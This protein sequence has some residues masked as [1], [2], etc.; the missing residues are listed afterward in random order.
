MTK[1]IATG[2]TIEAAVKAGLSQLQ[3]TEDR[4]KIEVLEQPSKGLF[5]FIG[6]KEAKVE[7]ELLPDAI[8]QAALFLKDLFKSMNIEARISQTKDRDGIHFDLR[9]PELGI[10]IGKRGQTLDALQYLVN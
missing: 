10:L 4:V 1:M 8:D 7:L 3:T 5:G 9:G 2:K 6:V